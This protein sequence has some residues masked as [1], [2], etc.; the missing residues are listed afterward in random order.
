MLFRSRGILVTRQISNAYVLTAPADVKLPEQIA[1]KRGLS[2]HPRRASVLDK[3]LAGLFDKVS[4]R[5][6]RIGGNLKH[7]LSPRYATLPG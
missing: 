7:P 3:A 5:V 4:G 6:H 1:L 2:F